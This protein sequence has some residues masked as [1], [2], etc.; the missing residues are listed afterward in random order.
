MKKGSIT[1]LSADGLIIE[2]FSFL[3]A[4]KYLFAKI[5]LSYLFTNT[6]GLATISTLDELAFFNV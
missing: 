6:K 5:E 1:N 4:D 2:V 3:R